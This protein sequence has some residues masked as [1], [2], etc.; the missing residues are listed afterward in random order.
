MP[1]WSKL[2]YRSVFHLWPNV[3]VYASAAAVAGLCSA[4]QIPL[5]WLLGSMVTAII[6]ALGGLPAHPPAMC[7]KAGQLCIGTGVG[8]NMTDTALAEVVRWLPLM[9]ATAIGS[10]L[11][12]SIISVF[13]AR[14]ARIDMKSSFFACLPGGLAEMGTVG[15]SFGA[16]PEPVAVVQALR[17]IL[18][19]LFVPSTLIALGMTGAYSAP[20]SSFISMYWVPTLILGGMVGVLILSRLRLNNPWML[21]GVIF[22][23][24]LA[25][26]SVVE[27]RM[28]NSVSSLGQ[29]LIGVAV[30]SQFRRSILEKMP[31][32]AAFGTLSI[33]ALSALLCLYS[34]ILAAIMGM[35]PAALI[36]ATAAGGMS[37]MSATAQVLHLAVPLVVSFQIVRSLVVN[38]LAS[39]YFVGLSRVGFFEL[40]ARVGSRQK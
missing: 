7:R 30:G 17:V 3:L 37:E 1:S 11:V 34:L 19:V 31:R 21:G 2:S 28:P 16:E 29:L 27:G 24:I 5:A 13:L 35:E 39:Y 32:L 8:L 36:L 6:L 20:S 14:F 12:T 15:K 18:V 23:A 10:V 9:L 38:G 33:A 25:S 4:L 40:V 26:S 22:A